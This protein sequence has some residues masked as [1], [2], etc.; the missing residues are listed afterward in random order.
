MA[1]VPKPLQNID[2]AVREILKY[3]ADQQG[4]SYRNLAV[5]GFMSHQRIALILRGER[6]A[7]LGEVDRIC[8]ALEIDTLTLIAAAYWK[9]TGHPP[10]GLTSQQQNQA[11]Q[12]LDPTS[13]VDYYSLAAKTTDYDIRAQIEAEQEE[14]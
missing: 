1:K 2:E 12:L 10:T 6:P 9:T 11:A 13:P 8:T 4:K 3:V 14:P 7:T 5:P